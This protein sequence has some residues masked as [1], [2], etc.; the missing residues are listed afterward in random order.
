MGLILLA[1]QVTIRYKK[2]IRYRK[3]F[4]LITKC[5][6]V[7]QRVNAKKIHEKNTEL[8]KSTSE[9]LILKPKDIP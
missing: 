4:E 2:S 3:V 7:S 5:D 1:L 9:L 8:G 6:R